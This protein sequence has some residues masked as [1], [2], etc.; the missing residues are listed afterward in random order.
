MTATAQRTRTQS[1]PEQDLRL[2]MLNTLLT[3]PHRDL[4]AVYKVHDDLVTQDPLFYSR[5][6]AWYH[7][8]G[9]IRD[10]KEM[11]CVTLCLSGFEGHRDVGCALAREL[12]P[13]QLARVVDFIHGRKDNKAAPRTTFK[14]KQ[15]GLI[16]HVMPPTE[17]A[18][19]TLVDYGLFR[20]VPSSLRTEV[21]RY[22]REREADAGWFDATALAARKQLK[23]L[24]AVLHIPPGE[25]A[26]AILFDRNP[27]ADSSLFQLKSLA[28][29]D[30]PADQARVILEQRIPYRVA[31]TVVS[32]MTP[33]VLLALVDVMSPQELLNNLSS[34]K[35]RGAFDNADIKAAIDAKLETAKTAKNVAA[36]KTDKVQQVDASTTKVLAEIADTQIK[37]KGRITRPTALLIDASGSMEQA[38]ELGKRIGAMLSAV[39][40]ADL[41][42]YAFDTAPYRLQAA[43][44]DLASWN[45]ALNGIR[46]GGGT[47]CGCPLYALRNEGRRIENVVLVSD[48]G[49][50]NNPQFVSE[51]LAYQAMLG[52]PLNVTFVKVPTRFQDADTITPALK[53]SGIAFDVYNM[54]DASDYYSLPS[55]I[56]YLTKPSKLDLLMEIL[57]WPLPVRKVA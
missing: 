28:Q 32:Q 45:V 29:A 2:A 37:A 14:A 21:M 50:N 56:P 48:G 19:R 49:E 13:Y 30:S 18:P 46:A 10:H 54:S 53:Q 47:S 38:I 4:G 42:A 33:A 15:Q 3:T 12:P 20:N 51:V 7:D 8:T 31:A 52:E 6:A 26:Q 35:R 16:T 23:R 36:L 11:F 1:S 43:G 24:Y 22:L 44:T 17:K 27:P 40:D 55:L 9:E 25:R 34:L 57:N 41:Y 39:M 5:L